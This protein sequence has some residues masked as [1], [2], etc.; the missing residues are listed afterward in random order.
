MLA[1]LSVVVPAFNEAAGIAAAVRAIAAGMPA[2]IPEW[3]IVVVDDG[4]ADGTGEVVRSMAARDPRIRWVA[5]SRNAGKG[6]ALR[7]GIA[8]SRLPWVLLLDADQQ[9]MIEE[10]EGIVANPRERD[11]VVGYRVGRR[12]TT[13]RRLVTIVYGLLVRVLLGVKARDVNCPFKLLRREAGLGLLQRCDGFAVDAELLFRLTQR[14]V[15]V[16]ELGV[17][18]CPREHGKSSIGLRH[19]PD[20]LR[21]LGWLF[22]QRLKGHAG[23]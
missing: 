1:G 5:H 15:Q 22:L 19:V 6:R 9:V 14:K 16:D 11:A 7:T 4:S 2:S 10:L 18:W 3:E 20:V 12:E 21:E 23:G 8:E 17:R 13:V